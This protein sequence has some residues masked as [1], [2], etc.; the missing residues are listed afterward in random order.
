MDPIMICNEGL[1]FLVCFNLGLDANNFS[2]CQRKLFK[3]KIEALHWH[4]YTFVFQ[5]YMPRIVIRVLIWRLAIEL[6]C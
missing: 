2:K 3:K 1:S 5:G 6:D 4:V